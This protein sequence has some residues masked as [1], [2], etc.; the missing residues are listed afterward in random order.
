M[1]QVFFGGDNEFNA[2]VFGEQHPGTLQHLQQQL[3]QPS[4][5][6]LGQAQ[7]FFANSWDLYEQFHGAEAVRLAEAAVRKVKGIFQP[8]SVRALYELADLQQAPPVMQRFLMACPEIRQAYHDQRVDGF[9]ESYVDMHPGRI[10]LAHYDYRRVVEGVLQ[11]VEDNPEYDWEHVEFLGDLHPDDRERTLQE[12]VDISTS[13]VFAKA[14]LREG[15]D[16]PVSPVG[17]KL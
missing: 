9:A 16:D 5:H 12:K 7:Q 17:G 8:D 14:Y 6:L 2:L 1:P 11:P 15:K 13:W 10:G 4:A 3:S